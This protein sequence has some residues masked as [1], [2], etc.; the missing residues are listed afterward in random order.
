MF[1]T[2]LFVQGENNCLHTE[3]KVEKRKKRKIDNRAEHII[4]YREA[5]HASYISEQTIQYNT[6]HTDITHILYD[7]MQMFVFE[8]Q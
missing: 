1:S 3:V 2:S 6:I 5:A 8:D 7:H 4:R